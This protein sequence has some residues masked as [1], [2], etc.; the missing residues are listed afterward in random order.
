MSADLIH[1]IIFYIMYASLALLVVIFIERVIYFSWTLKQTLKLDHQL[2]QHQTIDENQVEKKDKNPAYILVEPLLATHMTEN[3]RADVVEQ[4]YIGSKTALNRGIWIVETIVAAAP[5]LGLLGTVLGIVDTFQALAASGTS[6][7]SKV[8]GG[9][10]TALYATGLGIGI[11]L[12]ALIM[13][14]FLGSRMER[15]GE[16]SKILLIR[17]GKSKKS[18]KSH[19]KEWK[20]EA[21][22]KKT[23]A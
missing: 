2:T 11:A 20:T 15:I 23:F 18:K 14:N 8:S 17:A 13:N 12:I 6:D 22:D 7:A 5:L 1:N 9:M 19:A 3:E 10:G 16:V 21:T 4:Q